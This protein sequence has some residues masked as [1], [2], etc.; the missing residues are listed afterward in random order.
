MIEI[1]QTLSL[2]LC[3]G[4]LKIPSIID[5]KAPFLN[6]STIKTMVTTSPK[7]VST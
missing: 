1:S 4:I 3:D 6:D 7:V 5:E 2:K